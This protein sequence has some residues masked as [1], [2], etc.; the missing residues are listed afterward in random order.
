MKNRNRLAIVFALS[1]PVIA[2]A[3]TGAP[4]PYS[5]KPSDQMFLQA[6]GN[7]D[8]AA[9]VPLLDTDF[10]WIDSHGNR[11]NRA[12]FLEQFPSVANGVVAA[13]ERV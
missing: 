12:E 7:K 6:V 11:L 13:E 1:A 5:A 2:H 3:G 10:V 8:K 9:A 4:L